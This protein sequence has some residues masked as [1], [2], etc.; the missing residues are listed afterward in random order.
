MRPGPSSA[1]RSSASLDAVPLADVERATAAG[2][3]VASVPTARAGIIPH[4][5]VASE[6]MGRLAGSLRDA[7]P[8]TIV[9]I[10]P[11]HRNTGPARF[12]VSNSDWRWNASTFL[13]DQSVVKGLAQRP[14]VAIND[15]VIAGEHSVLT[16]LPFLAAR[17]PKA[18][19]VLIIV[20][21]DRDPAADG[22]LAVAFDSQL[23]RHDLVIAS[24][25]FSHDKPWA[26]ADLDDARSLDALQRRDRDA[27][28]T[29]PADSPASLRVALDFAERRAAT[30]LAVIDHSNSARVLRDPGLGATTSYLTAVW[31]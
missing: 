16:P 2:E 31:H 18:R 11:D 29:I 26:E 19:F 3:R 27:L 23:G 24:V 9:I 14:D 12:T 30:D 6:L 8:E 5:E 28:E 20:R 22:Q 17:F 25:D 10:G 21:A 13:A 4:H 7:S 1:S 15:D